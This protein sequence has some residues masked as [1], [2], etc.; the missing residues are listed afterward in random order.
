MFQVSVI[1]D[2]DKKPKNKQTK[3][4]RAVKASYMKVYKGFEALQA[5]I[6]F[7]V[8]GSLFH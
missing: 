3:V 1:V 4:A 8:G 6:V 7:C 5:I 2:L